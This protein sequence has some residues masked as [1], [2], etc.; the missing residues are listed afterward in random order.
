MN[1]IDKQILTD[2]YKRH[3]YDENGIRPESIKPKLFTLK[4]VAPLIVNYSQW[5]DARSVLYVIRDLLEKNKYDEA[6]E[7]IRRN[8]E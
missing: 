7:Y 5:A 8:M 3:G 6:T 1:N 4:E 2:F